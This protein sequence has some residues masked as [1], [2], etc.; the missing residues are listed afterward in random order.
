M[1]K[2]QIYQPLK[3]ERPQHKKA[4]SI[5]HKRSRRRRKVGLAD[6]RA[7]LKADALQSTIGDFGRW[8][9]G[10]ALAVAM[11]GLPGAWFKIGIV[12]L[13][14]PVD[15]WCTSPLP[16]DHNATARYKCTVPGPG[17]DGATVPC[18]SWEYDRSV[19]TETII[20]EWD[21][22]CHRA[23]LAN[24]VQMLFMFGFLVGC[25]VGGVVADKYG[26]KPPLLWGSVLML[27]AGVGCALVP[28][29]CAYLA[30]RFLSAVAVGAITVTGFV[31]TIEI[32]GGRWRT[33]VNALSG[34]PFS[35]GH[36]MLAG[37]AYLMR[38]W[39]H[40]QL[41]VSIP[42]VLQL[43]YVWL[44]PES[45]RWLIAV[46]RE[47]EA[48]EVLKK[49][50]SANRIPVADWDK[51]LAACREGQQ[52]GGD[53]QEQSAGFLALFRTPVM[54]RCTLVMYANWAACGL[55]FY[56][57]V[58]YM[59]QVAGNIFLNGFLSGVLEMPGM[60][61][62]CVSLIRWGRRKTLLAAQ[63]CTGVSCLSIMLVPLL[64]LPD[65]VT[66]A[67]ASC[68]VTGMSVAF[69]CVYIYAAELFPTVVRNIGV[70]SAST[71][72]R[73]GSMM[74]PFVAT[75]NSVSLC[76]PPL[77]FGLVPLAAGLLV[78]MLP[79]TLHRE[80]PDT[81]AEVENWENS[82]VMKTKDNAPAVVGE[83]NP[84]FTTESS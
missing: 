47:H 73:V 8:Q 6:R 71:I 23:Q 43:S 79:E 33:P 27:L 58:Q 22:V 54:R 39:H 25:T 63:V 15:F 78:Y 76:L 28:W 38:D 46:G 3:N 14:P 32:I 30:L 61:I 5:K 12:F 55:V 19:F 74:A 70:G 83:E 75:L 20:T 42:V 13:A 51:V 11:S 64:G 77:F 7:S 65:W 50:A 56:G 37:L 31:L 72:A 35:V 48:V 66:V 16:A 40:L 52:K 45:P 82:A 21:L 59:G 53:E 68:G 60:V 69:P 10:I 62:C 18:E 24:V 9:M 34:L 49:G 80:L 4:S 81:I 84:T 67:L 26:R 2:A 29:F 57:L 44:V 17:E 41:A 36:C 1:T